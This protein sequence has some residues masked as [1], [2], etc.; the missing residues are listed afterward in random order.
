MY[1]AS[2]N[3]AGAHPRI[4]DALARQ[5][6]GYA[7]AYGASDL[8]RRIE[9]SFNDL[10]GQ[11]VAVFFVST[12]TAANALALASVNRPGGVS[13]CHREAHVIEDEC[14]APEFFTHGAR[15]VPVDG[16]D[17]K[18]DPERLRG[19]IARFPP[20]FVHSG[21]P[22]A[23]TMTQASEIG[24]V[25]TPHETRAIAAI[26]RENGLPL[27]MDGA[28][29]ANALV[30]L[31]LRPVQMTVEAP[32]WILSR[33]VAP[34]TGAGARKRWL[35]FSIPRWRKGV[36]VH[37]QACS[38]VFSRAGLSRHSSKSISD[39]PLWLDHPLP[40]QNGMATTLFARGLFFQRRVA[41]W[42][43]ATV[44]NE[45]FAIISNER[46]R[47]LRA[48]G[49]QF[50]DW[51]P[52][53]SCRHRI[54]PDESLVRLVTSFATP[55]NEDHRTVCRT[56]RT[57]HAPET[58]RTTEAARNGRPLANRQDETCQLPRRTLRFRSVWYRP[59]P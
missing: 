38:T 52:P 3:W 34:K 49:A 43:G 7:A 29:F 18:M 26:A 15:L 53:R 5:A 48:A 2:D 44:T 10:F 11:E 45:V 30:E 51:H 42:P 14:G 31:E 58:V 21:Q 50:Y 24:T 4:N 57:G 8:D 39:D 28:R 1:F 9:A 33:L 37:S 36:P 17:G 27:H 55:A 22:M 40:R 12:G 54:G 47:Q 20:D 16:D 56:E 19:E 6:G 35:C 41:A 13:F 25:Y 23:I 59:W 32:G 46:I